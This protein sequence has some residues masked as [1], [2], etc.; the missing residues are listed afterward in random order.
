MPSIVISTIALPKLG[1]FGII[2]AVLL[3]PIG[4]SIYLV[5]FLVLFFFLFLF[6]R[7]T[8]LVLRSSQHVSDQINQVL[9]LL[10]LPYRQRGSVVVLH[11]NGIVINYHSYG[12]WALLTIKCN[13]S[14]KQADYLKTVILKYQNN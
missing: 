9:T 10:K 6:A 3:L 5:V 8:H 2:I 7:S 13:A 4:V 1:I 11:K 12:P 14:A